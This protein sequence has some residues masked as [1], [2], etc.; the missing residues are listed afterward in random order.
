MT[1]T[2]RPY[3]N[4]EASDSS[5]SP[6]PSADDFVRDATPINLFMETDCSA[7]MSLVCRDSLTC[8]RVVNMIH[9]WIIDF[10]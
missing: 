8:L 7:Q 10:Q 6:L 5:V 9:R 4:E 1:M 3:G 2:K